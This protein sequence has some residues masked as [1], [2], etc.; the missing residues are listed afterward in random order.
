MIND[1]TDPHSSQRWSRTALIARCQA[2]QAMGSPTTASGGITATEEDACFELLR[3]GLE[4]ND[5]VAWHAFEQQFQSLFYQWIQHDLTHFGMSN[6]SG[7]EREEIWAEARSRFVSRYTRLQ[8]LTDT[9][10]HIGAVLKVI[11]K[12]IRSVVQEARRRQERQ[13]RL[14]TA[15]EQVHYQGDATSQLPGTQVELA[16][17]RNCITSQIEHDLPE[18]ELRQLL[19]LRYVDELKP[20]EISAQY[21]DAYPDTAAVHK[22]LERIMKR[23]RR[24]IDQY[25]SRCL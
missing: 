18:T 5:D 14:I 16:E 15:I 17:L 19:I 12:C 6:T 23:L 20:R 7:E 3:R 1:S 24:R 11:Q 13:K 21:P 2:T 10:Y 8:Q 4:E 25:V 22:A 9:F